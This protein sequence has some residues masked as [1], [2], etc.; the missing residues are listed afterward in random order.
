MK[1]FTLLTAF[2]VLAS[3]T[4]AQV[5][6]TYAPAKDKKQTNKVS[7]VSSKQEAVWEVTFDEAE[8]QYSIGNHEGSRNW[9][10]SDTTDSDVTLV[11]GEDFN[12]EDLPDGFEAS[13]MWVYMGGTDVGEYSESGGNFA[14][15]DGI[16]YLLS[17]IYENVDAYIQFDSIDLS[18]VNNPKL[19]FTQ[20]YKAF[21]ADQ[22]FIDISTD[23][24]DTWSENIQ[25][26]TDLAANEYADDDF[27]KI[28]PQLGNESN[29]SFRLRWQA[30]DETANGPEYS[31]GYGWQVD[32]LKIIDNPEIDMRLVDARMNFFEYVDYT[33]PGNEDYFHS[34]SHYGMIP[35]DQFSSDMAAMI[36]NVI[37]EN[38]GSL[39][40]DP[41]LNITVLDPGENEIY[42]ESMTGPTLSLTEKDTLD[43]TSPEFTLND[44]EL[45]TYTVLYNLDITDDEN[46]ENNADT[47]HF[48]VT[49]STFA[50]DLD[51]ITTYVSPGTFSNGHNDGEM[52]AVNYIYL[53][54]AQV[55][56]MS[57][58]IGPNTSEGTSVVG[59]LMEFD[60]DMEEWVDIITSPLTNITSEDIGGWLELEFPEA[61]DV[62]LEDGAK[63]VRVAIEFYY[64]DDENDLSIGV[65]PSVPTS[66]W[67]TSW[68]MVAGSN[69]NT[70]VSFSNWNKGGLALR[71]NYTPDENAV[72]EINTENLSVY[73]NPSTGIVKIDNVEGN[74]IEVFNMMG[75]RVYSDENV[76]QNVK[77]NLSNQPTGTYMLRVTG[78]NGTKTQKI[79]LIK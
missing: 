20:N 66:F 44:P 53:Y 30:P 64:N 13:P 34:S 70:W 57:A 45:G 74:D 73:P 7:Q 11:N 23:G 72:N 10:V 79:N 43:L 6:G 59:H 17:G 67:G 2:V 19:M 35:K 78:T 3:F 60:E 18:T 16:T 49:D 31:G 62:L 68:Y 48:I 63:N 33:E 69:A 40:T 76:E 41:V 47:T 8:P 28:L 25:V 65:D 52:M 56:S 4:F 55:H 77:L 9:I 24:G 29:V 38:N 36:W 5:T 71:L 12:W 46:M 58:F 61:V 22:C 26:N 21:N 15:I 1:R 32:D 54:E 39:D 50:R 51:D 27:F 37:V 75:Q 42:N 14:Y